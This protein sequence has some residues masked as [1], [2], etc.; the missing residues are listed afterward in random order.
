M[1]LITMTMTI[2]ML[3]IIVTAAATH[4]T[5]PVTQAQCST[6]YSLLNPPIAMFILPTLPMRKPR[7]RKIKKLDQSRTAWDSNPGLFGSSFCA[8]F[9]LTWLALP[10]M[11]KQRGCNDPCR[12]A[13]L[14]PSFER[15]GI[16]GPEPWSGLPKG[17]Q[18]VTVEIKFSNSGLWL[19]KQ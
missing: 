10:R 16:W 4:R 8:H 15:K 3:L 14:G 9:L 5:S 11:L 2:R 18:L 13:T 12:L 19:S 7:P 6:W 1:L 17:T